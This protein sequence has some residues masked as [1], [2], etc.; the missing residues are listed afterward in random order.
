MA[1]TTTPPAPTT[2][3]AASAITGVGVT[4]PYTGVAN[5]IGNFLGTA[6]SAGF[7]YGETKL[8]T[9]AETQQALYGQTLGLAGIAA[10]GTSYFGNSLANSSA[11]TANRFGGGFFNSLNPFNNNAMLYVG[12]AVVVGIVAIAIFK[13]GKKS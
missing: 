2:N 11:A 5:A 3:P 4:D 9:Q 8:Q 6:V 1:D 7:Q 12:V 13:G 10:Q